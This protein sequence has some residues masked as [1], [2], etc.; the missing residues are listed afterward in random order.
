MTVTV[1][2]KSN[3][4]AKFFSD[5]HGFVV[6]KRSGKCLDARSRFLS[7]ETL[8]AQIVIQQLLLQIDVQPSFPFFRS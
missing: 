4:S 6:A 5:P 8:I 1:I 3:F 7:A 2:A